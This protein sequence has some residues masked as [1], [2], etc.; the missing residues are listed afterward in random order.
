M[1]KPDDDQAQQQDRTETDEP[2]YKAL[3]EQAKADAD[4]WKAMSRKNE[5][6]AKSNADAAQQLEDLSQRLST[7]EEE[8]ARLKADA[9]RATLVSKVAV[10]TGV[11]ESIVAA[12]RP[13]DEEALTQAAQ[14]IAEAYRVPGGAPSAPEAG[15]FSRDLGGTKTAA[16]KF[17]DTVDDLLGR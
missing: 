13:S 11:P 17:G 10:A 6:K 14:A 2:D 4:K 16:Q 9:D 5:G 1:P 15:T 8:N 12:L 3:W 7:I